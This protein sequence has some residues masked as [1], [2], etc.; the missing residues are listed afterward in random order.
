MLEVSVVVGRAPP[1]QPYLLDAPRGDARAAMD[2]SDALVVV[3]VTGGIGSGKSALCEALR[4][5]GETVIDC[6]KVWHLL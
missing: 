1:P 5:S 6:D 3:G 4:A 2:P